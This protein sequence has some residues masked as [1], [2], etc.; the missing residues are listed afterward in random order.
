MDINID[1]EA[2]FELVIVVTDFVL[3]I[4]LG[5][6]THVPLVLYCS[7]HAATCGSLL[8]YSPNCLENDYMP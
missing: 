7:P 8:K 1:N 4:V 3:Q 2:R 5:K 6:I